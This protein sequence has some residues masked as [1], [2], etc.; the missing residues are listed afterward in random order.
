MRPRDRVLAALSHE[1]PDR[2]PIDLGSCQVTSIASAAYVNLR[3]ALGLPRTDVEITDPVQQLALVEEDVLQALEV[4]TRGIGPNPPASYRFE[5]FEEGE[6]LAYY[7]EW[8]AKLRKPKEGGHY[9]D[10][11]EFPIKESSLEALETYRWPDPDDP[12]R[13]A[14]LREKARS[15]YENTDY[16]L[17]GTAPLGSDILAMPQRTR[18]YAESMMDLIAEPEFTEAFLE[19]LTQIALRAWSHF[20]DEVGEYI[21]VATLYEDL[22]TQ[23]GPLISPAIYRRL[24]KPREARIVELIKS[25]SNAKVFL[26][27]CGAI[28][29]F[30]PDFIDIGI[31]ILNP[32]QVAAAG[33]GDTAQLKKDFG[34]HLTFWGAACDSQRVFAF[35]TPEQAEAEARR[36]IRDLAPGGGF[37]F[38]PIHNIQD[39]VPAANILAVFRAAHEYGYYPIH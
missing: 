7:D 38:A 17:V 6:Y 5:V 27:C 24:V 29:E 1:E 32:I 22:G 30:I 35:A 26:H 14:G 3:A 21:Q 2:V 36:R 8:G 12:S 16:A 37:V 9:F 11:A 25:K 34:R 4:D 20:L 10:W 23:T 18:G 31:D 19:R 33:L 39:D 15:L 13:Y 28:R